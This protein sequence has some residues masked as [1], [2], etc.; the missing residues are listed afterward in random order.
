MIGNLF[1][2]MAGARQIAKRAA[3]SPVSPRNVK[4][5]A[6]GAG[7]LKLRPKSR[8]I[9]TPGKSYGAGEGNRTLVCSLG[10][11]RSAIELRPL[12]YL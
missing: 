7:A 9:D 6:R 4:L 3:V 1:G 11:C 12:G 2:L 8:G 10:S 5:V